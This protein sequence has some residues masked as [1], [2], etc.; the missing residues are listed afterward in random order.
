MKVTIPVGAPPLL[1]LMAAVKPTAAPKVEGL[2]DEITSAELAALFTT[3]VLLSLLARKLG[4][5]L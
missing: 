3:W 4:S 1:E 5:P 2:S